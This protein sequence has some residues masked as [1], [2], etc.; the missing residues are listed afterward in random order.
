MVSQNAVDIEVE[1]TDDIDDLIELIVRANNNIKTSTQSSDWVQIG[2]DV[3]R[4]QDLVD[5]LE[6]VQAEV[7]EQEAENAELQIR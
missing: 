4:L 1:S 3:Q 6:E 7:K 2:K 5:R